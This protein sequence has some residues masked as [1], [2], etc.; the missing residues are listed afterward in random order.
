MTAPRRALIVIDVQQE[1][2]EGL[3]P[4]QYPAREK[5]IVRI[6]EAIN[7]AAHANAPIVLVQHEM[8][9]SAPVFGLGSATFQNHPD[10]A[11]YEGEASKHISKQFGSIF[12]GTDLDTWLREQGIETITL[13]GYM[14]NNCIL[15]SAADAEP[16]GF[17]VEVLSDA[18]GAIDLVNEAGRA[19]AQ[20]VHDTLM[21]LLHSNWAAV[22]DTNT[23]IAALQAGETLDK[24]NLVTSA[25]QG[26]NVI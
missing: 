18:T 7:A 1:Y 5:S 9:A 22:T 3:L 23:W 13:V 14:T 25:A 12:A 24:S 8:P 21:V 26:R 4:I 20:Q 17:A 19:S 6:R 16:R 10:V 2:F 15:S 11:A